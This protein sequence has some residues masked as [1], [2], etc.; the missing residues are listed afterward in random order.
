MTRKSS[1][2]IRGNNSPELEK[3]EKGLDILM[4]R[5]YSCKTS[6]AHAINELIFGMKDFRDQHSLFTRLIENF[7]TVQKNKTQISYEIV[8]SEER[9]QEL[10]EELSKE[11]SRK[12]EIL[13]EENHDTQ[14]T[15]RLLMKFL[16]RFSDGSERDFVLSQIL[17]SNFT[18]YVSIDRN[19][20]IQFKDD[21]FDQIMDELRKEIIIIQKI[22]CHPLLGKRHEI[23]SLIL[24]IIDK[25]RD[26]K[27][28]V[29]LMAL[30]I[31]DPER[32]AEDTFKKLIVA[33]LESGLMP[34][35]SLS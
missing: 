22:K 17:Y 23:S 21:E 6:H 15:A 7:G 18:P 26:P 11:I 8:M 35:P 2:E 24:D 12:L 29:V 33:A 19:Q 28:R 27:K 10:V 4:G 14:E 5:R 1:Q 3:T 20:I 25:E 9:Y 31:Y 32:E 34:L 16:D 30:A 13:E